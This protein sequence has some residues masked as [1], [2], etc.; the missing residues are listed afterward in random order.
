MA[1]DGLKSP[2][3]EL[4]ETTNPSMMVMRSLIEWGCRL[5]FQLTKGHGQVGELPLSQRMHT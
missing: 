3:G 2:Y 4:P 1:S 5:A